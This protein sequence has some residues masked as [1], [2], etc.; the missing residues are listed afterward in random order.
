MRRRFAYTLAAAGLLIGVLG[1][2][3][4]ASASP[5]PGGPTADGPT[6]EPAEGEVCTTGCQSLEPT[7]LDRDAYLDL[8]RRFSKEEALDGIA[9]ETLLFHGDATR[10]RLA[11]EGTPG[12]DSERAGRLK[13][14]LERS[15]ARLSVRFVDAGGG[16]RLTLDSA[17]V[18]LGLKRHLWPRE[19][20]DLRPP[21]VSGTLQRVG[22]K[23]LWSRL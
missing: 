14:E 10:A 20:V 1:T 12:L 4:K 16:E 7:A 23:H 21:E 9:F 2:G 11:A 13:A 19:T 15:H 17:L 3:F 18:P 8:I 22:V 5:S 6:G